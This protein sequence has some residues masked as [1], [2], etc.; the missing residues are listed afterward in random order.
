[1][2]G[3]KVRAAA[4]AGVSLFALVALVACAPAAGVSNQPVQQSWDSDQLIELSEKEAA[5]GHTGQA[6]RLADGKVTFEEYQAAFNDLSAC[7]KDAGITISEPVISPVSNDRYEFTMDVG[8]LDVN[9][10]AELSDECNAEHWT[11]VSQGYMFTTTPVM[12]VAVRDATV[13][14]LVENGMHPSGDEKNAFELAALPEMD[15]D[16]L[17][18]CVMAA[19]DE[20]F[21]GMPSVTVTF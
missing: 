3:G 10:G 4:V 5:A 18:E 14:C 19:V 2:S 8:S 16:V 20:V 7:L 6:E 9:V 15:P 17:T 12:D 21:P 11:S 13:D 1:M